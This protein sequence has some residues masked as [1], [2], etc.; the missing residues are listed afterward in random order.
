MIGC[1]LCREARAGPRTATPWLAWSRRLTD[2]RRS[3][4]QAPRAGNRVRAGV[5]VGPRLQLAAVPAD[6]H[7]VRGP[8]RAPGG[9]AVDRGASG[10]V[11]P[12]IARARTAVGVDH[13]SIR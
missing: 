6:F 2:A 11:Q 4:L 1:A 3:S 12:K 7:V 8:P 9:T 5:G 10:R 13:E